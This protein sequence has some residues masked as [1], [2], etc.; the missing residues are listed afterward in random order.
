MLRASI[1]Q[2]LPIQSFLILFFCSLQVRSNGQTASNRYTLE[3]ADFIGG[4]SDEGEFVRAMEKDAQGN[5]YL[6]GLFHG[7]V[8]FDPGVG[9]LFLNSTTDA[10]VFLCKMNPDG[11]LQ[12]A[13]QMPSPENGN[14]EERGTSID[15]DSEGNIYI[16]GSSNVGTQFVAKFSSSGNFLWKKELTAFRK[17]FAGAQ[18]ETLDFFDILVMNDQLIIA[19]RYNFT[20]DFDPSTSVSESS[21]F[22]GNQS[23]VLTTNGFLLSWS[24]DGNFNW[25][26]NFDC[27]R[28]GIITSLQKDNSNGFY[29]SGI[30][31][32]SID[33][34]P[35]PSANTIGTGLSINDENS[36][37]L[38]QYSNIG[39]FL[40]G[41][42]ILNTEASSPNDAGLTSDHK[43]VK[44]QHGDLVLS[45]GFTG[46]LQ[47]TSEGIPAKSH[48][49]INF[50]S[51]YVA[52]FSHEG[53]YLWSHHIPSAASNI[54]Q[55]FSISTDHKNQIYLCGLFVGDCNFDM[56]TSNTE[57]LR[58]SQ[59]T[60]NF[61][62]YIA[63]YDASGNYLDAL[64]LKSAG[65]DFR[66][67]DELSHF[68]MLVDEDE[69]IY[70]A[71]NYAGS[72]DVSVDQNN[73][74]TKST[75]VSPVN[76]QFIDNFFFVK[77]KVELVTNLAE[78]GVSVVFQAQVY[79]NP[80]HELLSINVPFYQTSISSVT[81]VDVK[82]N[83]IYQEEKIHGNSIQI[84]CA[85]WPTGEYVVLIQLGEEVLSQKVLIN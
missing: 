73:P 47:F 17:S 8:D 24:L 6:T 75:N 61:D 25:V 78:K 52:K 41:E 14:V 68:P 64:Q 38:A 79:P 56:I 48:R 55:A 16:G 85:E 46:N 34:D 28:R 84:N 37:F 43:I 60:N 54:N 70:F 30:F 9:S 45:G 59:S 13:S 62:I 27:N 69:N 3:F 40:W 31:A 18:F 1:F 83:S 57:A 12:W 15:L 21:S 77:Y 36:I 82:G 35:D 19:G 74:Q 42:F 39:T 80:A 5:V 22:F 65:G 58:V 67:A 44:D 32:G 2:W 11:A 72:F 49:E 4:F 51:T 7:M 33:I 50:T 29:A 71:F 53:T 76:Q 10:D 26:K 63:K 66:F 23:N 81:I 20:V